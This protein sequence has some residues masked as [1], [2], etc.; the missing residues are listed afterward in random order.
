MLAALAAPISSHGALSVRL[1]IRPADPRTGQRIVFMIRTY[2][3]YRAPE[4]PCG[5]RYEPWRVQ[6][7]FRVE[8]V[9][10]LDKVYA[11]RVRQA[12]GNRYVGYLRLWRAGRWTIRVT[13]FGPRYQACGPWDGLIRFRVRR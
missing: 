4:R 11:L 8:V 6:Y 5:L 1:S 3:P 12:R 9:T 10:P 2:V 13:N 7:P